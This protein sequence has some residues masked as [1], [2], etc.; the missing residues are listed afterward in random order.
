MA[1]CST[2]SLGRSRRSFGPAR[3]RLLRAQQG[4]GRS[5]FNLWYH[6]SGRLKRDVI[7]R[8]DVEFDHFCWLEGSPEVLRYE[9]EPEPVILSVEA[10]PTRTQFDAWVQ[11]RGASRPQLREIKDSEETLTPRERVQREAQERAAVAAGFDY[12]RIT[13]TDLLP[14]QQLIR[15]WRSALAFIAAARE[16]VLTPYRAEL[17]RSLQRARRVSLESLLAG[18]DPALRPIYLAAVFA[19]LQECAFSSDL[20]RQPLC[21]ATTIWIGEDEHV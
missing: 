16:L 1:T 8:S 21:A 7:L 6:Y 2:V 13:R 3:N 17:S 5:L 4:R 15:N 20:E 10:Q 18:T 12:V 14:H 11:L 19:A 9:L